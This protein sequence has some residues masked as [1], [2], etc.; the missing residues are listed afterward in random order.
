MAQNLATIK[1]YPIERGVWEVI[2]IVPAQLLG[3]K[4]THPS[5]TTQLRE[6]AR[7]AKSVGQPKCFTAF[8]EMALE[9][10]L[11]IQELTNKALSARHVGIML[12]PAASDRQEGSFF[13]FRLDAVIKRGIE[14]FQPLILLCLRTSESMFWVTIHQ[15]ALIRPGSSD[16]T[17]SLSP[18]PQPACVYVAM[19]NGVNNGILVGLVHLVSVHVPNVLSSNLPSS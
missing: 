4:S 10:S 18:R 7:V 15:I 19:A 9:E 6:L 1:G 3:E 11:T 2:N 12:H 8:T 5:Q 13:N 16:F 17:L 14:F